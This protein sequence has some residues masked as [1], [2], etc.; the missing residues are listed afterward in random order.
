M[1]YE[2]WST[3]QLMQKEFFLEIK[4]HVWMKIFNDI[5]CNLNWFE[6]EFDQI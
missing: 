1:H 2:W 6:I 4:L 3:N 5:A